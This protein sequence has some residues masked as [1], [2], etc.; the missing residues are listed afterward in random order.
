VNGIVSAACFHSAHDSA[1]M[2]L[3]RELRQI[4]I[5]SNLLVRQAVGD[6]SDKLKLSGR[7]RFPIIFRR[8]LSFQIRVPHFA[9][10]LNH[11]HAQLRGAGRLSARSSKNSGDDFSRGSIL[12]QVTADPKIDGLQ[13]RAGVFVH[14]EKYKLDS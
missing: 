7:K 1:D 6:E 10:V 12:E 13:E 4:Q 5:R 9:E 8:I 2:I 11:C 14:S 3:H